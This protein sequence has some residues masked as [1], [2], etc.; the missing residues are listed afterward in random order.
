MAFKNVS[1]MS[2]C[3]RLFVPTECC[4]LAAYV[5]CT[6]FPL[7]KT[8]AAFE[9]CTSHFAGLDFC[10]KNMQH[11]PHKSVYMGEKSS[12]R[13]GLLWYTN[14]SSVSLLISFGSENARKLFPQSQGGLSRVFVNRLVSGQYQL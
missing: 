9:I 10:S 13:P 11:E 2:K 5:L 8:N 1:D 6:L 12:I 7:T 3:V 4:S 14:M